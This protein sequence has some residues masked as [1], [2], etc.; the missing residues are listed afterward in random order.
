[1]PFRDRNEAAH[2]LAEKLVSYRGHNPL[3]LAIPRGAVPMASI[4]SET[5]EGELDVV[6]A[7]KIPAPGNSE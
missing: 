4:I 1:M 2:L 7:A 6:L 5:L 3:I